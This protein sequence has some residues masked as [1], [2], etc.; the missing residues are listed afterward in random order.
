MQCTHTLATK[1]KTLFWKYVCP[2][3]MQTPLEKFRHMSSLSRSF[4]SSGFTHTV[5]ECPVKFTMH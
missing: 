3:S 1:E 5:S 4:S 2:V